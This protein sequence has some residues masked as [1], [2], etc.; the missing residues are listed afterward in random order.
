MNRVFLLLIMVVSASAVHAGVDIQ[1]AACLGKPDAPIGAIYLHGMFPNSNK[2]PDPNGFKN[3][4]A[5]NLTELEALAE[6]MGIRIAVPIAPFVKQTVATKK[7]KH[8]KKQP[9]LLGV[10]YWTS[11][12]VPGHPTATLQQI[13]KASSAACGGEPIK[14][15]IGLIGF[16][17]GA[18][19]ARILC[20]QQ[21]DFFAVGAIGYN[22]DDEVKTDPTVCHGRILEIKEHNA[23]LHSVELQ[24]AL[25]PTTNGQPVRTAGEGDDVA[26]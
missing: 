25:T 22:N 10:R 3:L 13:L 1:H 16:S 6:K 23:G 18:N 19:M 24:R 14:K 7:K 26:S 5:R 15:P 12:K 4:E 21:N 11:S 8:S 9:P 2:V 17:N 20:N